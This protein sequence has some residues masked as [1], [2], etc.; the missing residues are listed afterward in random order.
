MAV[1]EHLSLFFLRDFM[2]PTM[3]STIDH[4]KLLPYIIKSA[5]AGLSELLNDVD[6][7]YALSSILTIFSHDIELLED[8][9]IIFDYVFASGSMVVP[10]YLYASMVISR[11]EELKA[12]DT[13]DCDILHS[14]LSKFPSPISATALFDVTARASTLLELYPPQSLEYWNLISTFSV[15]KTTAAPQPPGRRYSSA[16]YIDS[17]RRRE[18]STK[19][20]LLSS[21]SADFDSLSIEEEPSGISDTEEEGLGDSTNTVNSLF[22]STTVGS[23]TSPLGSVQDSSFFS[24][25]TDTDDD[26]DEKLTR[27]TASVPIVEYTITDALRLMERQIDEANVKEEEEKQR[28]LEQAAQ[29]KKELELRRAENAKRADEKAAAKPPARFLRASA[30]GLFSSSRI[31]EVFPTITKGSGALVHHLTRNLKV[32]SRALAPNTVLGMSIYFGLFSILAYAW[33]YNQA[34]YHNGGLL[35]WL[36]FKNVWEKMVARYFH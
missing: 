34:V 28:K 16:H 24:A 32:G 14:T 18:S 35:R 6:P 26:Q 1:L 5:D 2:M 25:V 8:T 4:L 36:D 23:L 20:R 9:C 30:L 29:R 7:F 21:S 31:A 19:N 3:T 13:D 11:K 27:S 10:L 17:R 12:L 15:L 33:Y 22:D